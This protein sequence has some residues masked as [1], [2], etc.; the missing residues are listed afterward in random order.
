[1]VEDWSEIEDLAAELEA[2]KKYVEEEK[3]YWVNLRSPRDGEMHWELNNY[4][5]EYH[6]RRQIHQKIGELYG[7]DKFRD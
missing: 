3:P 6:K 4:Y 7:M 1:M 2:Q 5:P